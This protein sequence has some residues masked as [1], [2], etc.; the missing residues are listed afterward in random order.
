MT[1][2]VMKTNNGKRLMAA[3]AVLALIACAFVALTP[4]EE[5]EA[6][7][8]TQLEGTS[9]TLGSTAVNV[10]V[11]T[12]PASAISFTGTGDVN[13]YLNDG[14]SITLPDSMDSINVSIG[15]GTYDAESKTITPVTGLGIA[16]EAQGVYSAVDNAIQSEATA[17][18]GFGI[19]TKDADAKYTY[20]PEGASIG[21]VY[22]SEASTQVVVLNGSVTVNGAATATPGSAINTIVIENA[23]S[24]DATKLTVDGAADGTLTVSGT[25]T[26]GEITVTKGKVAV[27]T[28]NLTIG[29]SG[30]GTSATAGVL[31]AANVELGATISDLTTKTT[32]YIYGAVSTP[33]ATEMESVTSYNFVNAT[34]SNITLKNASASASAS[35]DVDEFTGSFSYSSGYTFEMESGEI[36]LR[37]GMFTSDM[38]EIP[39]ES[40]LSVGVNA[41]LTLEASITLDSNSVFN[42]YG[43]L[44]GGTSSAKITITDKPTLTTTGVYG[45]FNSFGTARIGQHVMINVTNANIASMN[46]FN[47]ANDLDSDV[48]FSQTQRV[49]ITDSMT[50][51]S[52]VEVN[53]YGELVINEGVTM[54][55][56]PGAVVNVGSADTSVSVVTID[57][58]LVI[59]S[60]T[61]LVPTDGQFNVAGGESVDISGTVDVKGDISVTAGELTIANG[62]KV[63]VDTMG[64][65]AVS[66]GDFIVQTGAELSI[67]GIIS[68]TTTT[69][70]NNA[71]LVTINNEKTVTAAETN[72]NAGNVVINLIADGAVADIDSIVLAANKTLTVSDEGL[73]LYRNSGVETAVL[74]A[75]ANK[76]VIGGAT[77]DPTTNN[78]KGVFSGVVFTADLTSASS[79]TGERSY[80]HVIDI[81]GTAS[82][83]VAAPATAGTIDMTITG[84]ADTEASA[85]AV[86][87]D[88]GVVI[89]Q[90]FNC[91]E[92]VNVI[93]AGKLDVSGEMYV[94]ADDSSFVNN[95]GTITVTGQI[96]AVD[97]IAA[98]INAAMYEATE[99]GDDF[100]YYTTLDA[101]LEAADEIYV[102][103]T[104]TLTETTDI[105]A[106]TTVVIDNGNY[107]VIGTPDNRDVTLTVTDGAVL[108]NN[109]EIT[110]NGTLV[111]ADAEEG[112]EGNGPIISD[113]YTL[114]GTTAKYTNIYTALN[115]LTSGTVTITKTVEDLVL[116]QDLIVPS[117][118]TL[119]APA[120]VSQIVLAD[121]VTLTVQNNATLEVW[122]SIRAE[123]A[124]ADEASAVDGTSA[125]VI[126]GVFKSTDE[127]AYNLEEEQSY[128]TAGAYFSI[129]ET[130]ALFFYITPVEVAAPMSADFENGEVDIYGENTV[131]DVAFTGTEE[132][133]VIIDVI[134]DVDAG[135]IDLTWATIRSVAGSAFTGTVT[136]DSGAI[137][138][139]DAVGF[140]VRSVVSEETTYMYVSGNGIT[141]AD[142]TNRTEFDM[143]IDSGNVYAQ[144]TSTAPLAV[145]WMTIAA[146]ATFTVSGT[147]STATVASFVM[148]TVNG[149]LDVV[150][151]GS[152]TAGI[153]EVFGTANLGAATTTQAAGTSDIVMMFVGATAEDT[154]NTGLFGV[155][156][157]SGTVNGDFTADMVF[158][159]SG[160]TV[161]EKVTEGMDY[162]E[163]YINDALFMTVYS[164]LDVPIDIVAYP[165]IPGEKVT[166]W[167]VDDDGTV[168]NVDENDVI[169]SYDRTDAKIDTEVYEITI[170]AEYGI[171]D[172]YVDGDLVNTEGLTAGT[173]TINLA[174]GE[175]QI[176]YRLNNYF[177]GDVKI[178]LNGEQL[179][180]GKFTITSDMPFENDDGTT[181]EYKIV[182]TG[183]QAAAPDT[184]SQGGSSSD[185]MGLTDY[186]LII[187]VVLIVVMAIMVALRLMRS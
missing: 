69:T 50:V 176:T 110:V 15:L 11:N 172:I 68:G 27:G 143:T 100:V 28:G 146:G 167:Q 53:I 63:N 54:T 186:L 141:D 92:Y 179:T 178:T 152:I 67:R 83:E 57:G 5:T 32:P 119:V 14:V 166:A 24:V 174:V 158:A 155:L 74:T 148:I 59:Q 150:S 134:G 1:S 183:V 93:N 103:G 122:D 91:G 87:V 64:S 42:V 181:T 30:S 151:N 6:V 171:T 173:M 108:E 65:I 182:L 132:L 112:L 37:S 77:S 85:T 157:A 76:I 114:D 133:P 107:L 16:G 61:T 38:T 35:V 135:S 55:I 44:L 168:R 62:G 104:I 9:V 36:E 180:D 52:G 96:K 88:R 21:S 94:T 161:D 90:T 71:G 29:T 177:A 111:I 58:R 144:G 80:T 70:I 131:G 72:D 81:S 109:G 12:T 47:V 169:G 105:P 26:D 164:N 34:V 82:F 17:T 66:G 89:T 137:T 25:Y 86:G 187:L 43:S 175:H 159:A 185:G 45:E 19:Y 101:A 78:V 46:V 154:L 60:A 31:I 23:V 40:T 3:V 165:E 73:V 126:N 123:T 18:E 7:P 156:G 153:M 163:Y 4:S 136:S 33:S 39:A 115:G 170:V 22:L 10:Y 125:I 13:F 139:T 97:E 79:A 120:G 75:N 84:A 8:G 145:D 184:P 140:T 147:T 130:A 95:A 118:V 41:Q 162:T 2:N 20:Y 102:L 160:T 49:V 56:Q 113:V 51:M 121:G 149:T 99:N 128:K 127:N 106:E 124:F 129:R 48:T 98:T 142:D 116:N 138:F 117:G